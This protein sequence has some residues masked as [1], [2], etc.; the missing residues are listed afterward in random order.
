VVHSHPGA[1]RWASANLSRAG[2]RT[3][4]PLYAVRVRDPV[5]PTQTR[6]VERPLF[7]SYL[8]VSMQ[9]GDPWTPIRYAQGVHAV[10]MSDGRPHLV[11]AA[12]LEAL[13]AGDA[14]RRMVDAPG[15]SWA[16]GAPCTVRDGAF[17]GIPAA[18]V[19][20]GQHV[21][22]IALMM[23]GTVREVEVEASALV[24]RE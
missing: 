3:Y 19:A 7:P 23:F 2:Y 22:R 12:I 6:I 11:A 4:L 10:L 24:A 18:V 13:Q 5:L 14:A 8:F 9:R 20:A 16:A 15:A 17:A 21:V 1:E